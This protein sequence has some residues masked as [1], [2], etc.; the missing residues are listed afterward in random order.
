M[1]IEIHPDREFIAVMLKCSDFTGTNIFIHVNIEDSNLCEKSMKD[2]FKSMMHI[3]QNHHFISISKPFK[4]KD[5][6][7]YFM[8]LLIY[9]NQYRPTTELQI[10]V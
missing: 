4:S 8:Q 7:N 1:M 5:M 6:R 10:W 9:H 2:I 3:L